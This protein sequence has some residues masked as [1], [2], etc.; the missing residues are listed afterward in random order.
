MQKKTAIARVTRDTAVLWHWDTRSYEILVSYLDELARC[1]RVYIR[2]V[3]YYNKH[4]DDQGVGPAGHIS[5][6]RF[7]IQYIP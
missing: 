4:R 7:I 5:I 1:T 6:E 2:T 3:T